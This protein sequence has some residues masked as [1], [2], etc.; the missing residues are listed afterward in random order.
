M[1]LRVR[2]YTRDGGRCRYCGNEVGKDRPGFRLATL[3]HVIPRSR[4]GPNSEEN[5]VTS[6]VDCNAWKGDRTVEQ[7]GMELLPHPLTVTPPGY[8]SG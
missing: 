6:C 3:D 1:P 5:L 7:A 8:G 2:I 4:G